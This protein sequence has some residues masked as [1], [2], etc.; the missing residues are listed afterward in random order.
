[1][2][3]RRTETWFFAALVAVALFLTWLILAPYVG[4][5]IIA[6]TL[7]F[8]FQPLYQKLVR[9]VRYHAIAAA[10]VVIIVALIVFV[11]LGF[12]GASVLGDAT[13]L[14]S[15][16]TSHGSFNFEATTASFLGSHFKNLDTSGIVSAV[17]DYA[18][19]GLTWLIQ[20]LG[21]FF[22][23]IAQLFFMAF[24]SL[25]GLFYFLKDGA[26]LKKWL[27]E[28]VPLAP[29]YS[30]DIVREAEAVGSAVIKGTLVVAIV[31]GV[32]MG[33]GFFLFRIPDPTFWG[34]LVALASIIPIVGTWIVVVPAIAY[35]F[36]AGQGALGVG[37]AI[38]SIVLV[39][40]IYNVL[41]PQLMHR[42]ANIHPYLILLSVLGGLA[43]FGPIGFLAGPLAIAF[44]LS[45][46]KIYPK[47]TA[48]KS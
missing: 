41:S 16:L 45:L 44:L 8:L 15:S 29:E 38:W 25:L 26:A 30:E 4:A 11:P 5:L 14:Y 20:H 32:V 28:V 31:Q 18:Q 48:T 19:Q 3:A 35:L 37:L 39:N 46:L 21:S 1:M 43:L 6:G 47:L 42:G 9:V 12:F 34:T 7:A 10:C 24:V 36:F 17:N 13:A 22:S 2:D 27:V 33:L 23:G 40:L